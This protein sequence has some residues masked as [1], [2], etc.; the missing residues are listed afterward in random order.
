M[1]DEI[2]NFTMEVVVHAF[3][4]DYGTDKVQRNCLYLIPEVSKGM[5]TIPRRFWWPLNRILPFNFGRA[6]K[7]RKQFDTMI[8][9]VVEK[10]R[11]ELSAMD[12]SF[13]RNIKK[14]LPLL[15]RF[16]SSSCE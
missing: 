7:A 6:M 5:L 11:S 1:V 3:L 9:G 8:A 4:G 10:R 14:H 13:H 12:V 16:L 2:T 15:S